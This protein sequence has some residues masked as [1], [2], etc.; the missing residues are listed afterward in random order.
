[1]DDER[2]KP[3]VVAVAG[4]LFE[5]SLPERDGAP[6]TLTAPRP[7]EATL[8]G[9]SVRG[10]RRHFRLRAEAGAAVAGRVALRFRTE[11]AERGMSIRVVEVPVA[12]ER[13]S[14]DEPARRR[15]RP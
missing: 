13:A 1:V 10:D 9:E 4:C 3:A 11:T 5:V 15:H 14:G 6:W 7:E 8:V 2:N 12:P